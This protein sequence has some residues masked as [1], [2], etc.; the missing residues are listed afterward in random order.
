MAASLPFDRPESAVV[1]VSRAN[2]H[3]IETAVGDAS[4]PCQLVQR[5]GHIQLC[6]RGQQA[7]VADNM[8]LFS[9]HYDLLPMNRVTLF[10]TRRGL[11]RFF[12]AN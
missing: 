3:V 11:Y 8:A 10:H 7:L 12:L 2:C 6:L 5:G 1:L 9:A 4:C